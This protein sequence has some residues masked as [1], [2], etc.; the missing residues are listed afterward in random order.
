M[1]CVARTMGSGFPRVVKKGE[2]TNV[3]SAS[4]KK[5]DLGSLNNRY[6]VS[7][8]AKIRAQ[9]LGIVALLRDGKPGKSNEV[10]TGSSSQAARIDQITARRAFRFRKMDKLTKGQRAS[11][12]NATILGIRAFCS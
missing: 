5:R 9:R 2:I 12:A 10:L 7:A 1:V 3:N 8:K 6:R 4:F 11:A